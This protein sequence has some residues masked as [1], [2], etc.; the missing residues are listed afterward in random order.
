MVVP[1]GCCAFCAMR[2]AR[3]YALEAMMN[4]IPLEKTDYY[5]PTPERRYDLYVWTE[6]GEVHFSEDAALDHCLWFGEWPRED[7]Y[8]EDTFDPF[9]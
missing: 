8:G 5:Q 7:Y 3:K 2:D 4:G 1:A 6:K 9:E